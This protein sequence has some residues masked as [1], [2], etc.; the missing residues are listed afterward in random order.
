MGKVNCGLKRNRGKAVCRKSIKGY[1]VLFRP[2][3]NKRWYRSGGEPI[4]GYSSKKI[5]RQEFTKSGKYEY[6]IRRK[7]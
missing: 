3:G 7:L 2:R 4:G 5:A 1:E 6:K